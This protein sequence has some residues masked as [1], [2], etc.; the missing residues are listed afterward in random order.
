MN[1]KWNYEPPTPERKQQAKELA[2]KISMSP[3]LAELLIQRVFQDGHNGNTFDALRAPGRINLARVS[4]PK[5]FGAGSG[6]PFSKRGLPARPSPPQTLRRTLPAP[7]NKKT[8]D[9]QLSLHIVLC[10]V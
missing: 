6:G 10:F 3:I 7:Q 2:E 5:V 1:F 8:Q 4:A 9:K